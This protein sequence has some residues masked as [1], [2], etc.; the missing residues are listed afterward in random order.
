MKQQWIEIAGQRLEAVRWGTGS[1]VPI[2]LLH[3]GLG[4]IALWKDFPAALADACGREVFAWSRRGHGSSAPYPGSRGPDYMRLEAALLPAVHEA[5][6]LSH[7]HWFGHS[8]GGS[9]ALIAAAQFP[10]LAVSLILEAPHVFVETMTK[11][12]ISLAALDFLKS[13]MGERMK[14]YHDAPE[15][16]FED[17]CRTWLSAEFSDW[18]IEP[19]LAACGQPT[20][21]IQGIEDQY[22]TMEQL[23]RIQRAMPQSVRLELDD[24]KHSP[25]FD[26]RDAVIAATCTFL[27]GKD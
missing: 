1:G 4:S 18:N 10:D 8:D 13:D 11:A 23:D 7:A 12:S 2:L 27:D 26:A 16:L 24:C 15:H 19:Q 3:E 6:G 22:G 17:W 21:L 5:L 9:I 25:H 14:R 20:L